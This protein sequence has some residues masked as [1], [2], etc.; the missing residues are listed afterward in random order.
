MD[1]FQQ[2][3]SKRAYLLLGLVLILVVGGVAA[4]ALNESGNLP[5]PTNSDTNGNGNGNSTTQQ[6]NIPS[7]SLSD[8]VEVIQ[9]GEEV[10][11]FREV[12]LDPFVL[13]NGDSQQIIVKPGP[14]FRDVTAEVK[15]G[16]GTYEKRFRSA[17][18]NNNKVYY[19]Q[20]QPKQTT[21]GQ[22]YPVTLN[23]YTE[24]GAQHTFTISWQASPN[25]E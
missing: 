9:M 2:T 12:I 4:F 5:D 19:L 14:D 22:K 1:I 24:S 20:W 10:K 16:T 25:Y 3:N 13:D 21:S 15:D 8:E 17:T 11:V 6:T 18:L 7:L 23:S